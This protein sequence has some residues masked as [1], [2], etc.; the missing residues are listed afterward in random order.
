MRGAHTRSATLFHRHQQTIQVAAR[1]PRGAR[2]LA[3]ET[4]HPARFAMTEVEV[5]MRRHHLWRALGGLR[6]AA[7]LQ[8]GYG[9]VIVLRAGDFSR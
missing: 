4:V 8:D 5:A 7:A 2:V 9:A 6:L 3:H 1:D